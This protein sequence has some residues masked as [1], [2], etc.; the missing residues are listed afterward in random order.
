MAIAEVVGK[1]GGGESCMQKWPGRGRKRPP[2]QNEPNIKLHHNSPIWHLMV[3]MV[4]LVFGK[5]CGY[6]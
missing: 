6:C 2:A 3:C 4:L 5:G 1:P